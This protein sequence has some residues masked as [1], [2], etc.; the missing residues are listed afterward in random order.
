MTSRG[1]LGTRA[2]FRP[3]GQDFRDCRSRCSTFFLV[4]RQERRQRSAF[5]AK[6]RASPF[7]A[8]P[9][10]A[11]NALPSFHVYRCCDVVAISCKSGTPGRSF[12]MRDN[13]SV[14]FVLIM[15]GMAQ[16]N[17]PRPSKIRIHWHARLFAEVW[18]NDLE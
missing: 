13:P 1:D 2:Q 6:D 16:M 3:A 17:I 11:S 8:R 9:G 5:G 15:V 7:L 12:A 4:E 10:L 14:G 18:W